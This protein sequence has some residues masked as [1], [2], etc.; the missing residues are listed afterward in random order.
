MG[1][2]SGLR[3]LV[4]GYGDVGKT[5]AVLA[6]TLGAEIIPV[7]RS[8]R[9]EDG[10]EILGVQSLAE[11]LPRAGLVVLTA[12]GGSDGPLLDAERLALLRP[13]AY[14]VNVG[15]GSLIDEDALCRSLSDGRIAGA[16]IDV[17]SAEP[18]PGDSPLWSA[19]NLIISPHVA[20]RGDT[21]ALER[22]GALCR[23]NVENL[24]EGR[25]LV[26]AIASNG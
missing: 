26:G 20:G 8:A 12:P 13:S 2:F 3:I 25:Q 15:R 5:F 24:L 4:V 1:S 6:R 18:L 22:L 11:W 9:V 14:V 19:P 23:H 16:G 21:R 17:T 7:A 10:V